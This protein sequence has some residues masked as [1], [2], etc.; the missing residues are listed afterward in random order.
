MR[1]ANAPN[2]ETIRISQ[3]FTHFTHATKISFYKQLCKTVNMHL[4]PF[5][6]INHVLTKPGTDSR[7]V[8]QGIKL[9]F[10]HW[11]LSSLRS[12][13]KGW[14]SHI[15]LASNKAACWQFHSHISKCHIKK[16][17]NNDLPQIL[18]NILFPINTTETG[19]FLAYVLM[20]LIENPRQLLHCY[21]FYYNHKNNGCST[22]SWIQIN[23]KAIY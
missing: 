15:P 4:G 3:D 6:S 19:Y 2:S 23:A 9:I 5:A 12:V 20:H 17:H 16:R 10:M 7:L 18:Q 11:K 8:H 13:A 22:Q 1:E 14:L 21:S